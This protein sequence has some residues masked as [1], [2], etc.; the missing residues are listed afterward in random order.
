MIVSRHDHDRLLA[1][2]EVP[3]P[4]Q[5]HAVAVRAQD[6][7]CQQS[8]LL[9]RLRNVHLAEVDPVRLRIE[10]R[11]TVEEI[12]RADGGPFVAILTVPG[13]IS[14]PRL[15]H[16]TGEIKGKGCGGAAVGTDIPQ[17]DRRIRRRRR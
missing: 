12:E 13:R 6:E 9:V 14:L 17:G 7:V 10:S 3:E 15:H 8:L 1:A 4:R 11:R 5:G 2:G 16:R